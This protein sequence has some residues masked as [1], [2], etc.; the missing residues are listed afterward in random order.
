MVSAYHKDEVRFGAY[1][2]KGGEVGAVITD[3][4]CKDQ[5][6]KERK[7]KAIIYSLGTLIKMRFNQR[8]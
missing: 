2:G 3:L 4:S 5:P 1:L 7:G 6:F 8:P